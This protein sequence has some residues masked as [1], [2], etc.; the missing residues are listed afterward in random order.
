MGGSGDGLKN[1]WGERNDRPHKI[2]G[3]CLERTMNSV[4]R[5]YFWN[6]YNGCR[7][8]LHRIV[9]IICYNECSFL[10]A[11]LFF[12]FDWTFVTV[13]LFVGIWGSGRNFIWISTVGLVPRSSNFWETIW[14]N[15]GPDRQTCDY[16]YNGTSSPLDVG[17][18]RDL[19]SCRM[20]GRII[21]WKEW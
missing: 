6:S 13:Y 4:V 21:S 9:L 17:G 16:S 12:F 7:V 11:N 2:E 10:V 18:C 8:K 1:H 14:W 19:F 15:L 5:E 3:S 20:F